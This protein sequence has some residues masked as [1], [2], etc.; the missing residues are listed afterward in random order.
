MFDKHLVVPVGKMT[1]CLTSF[2]SLADAVRSETNRPTISFVHCQPGLFT[3][4]SPAT[5]FG[6]DSTEDQRLVKITEEFWIGRTE[7]TQSQWKAVMGTEPWS[8]NRYLPSSPNHPACYVSWTDAM[9]FCRKL[10]VL[11]H[12][13]GSL[14]GDWEYTLPTEIQ[15]EYACR[16][17][18]TT[19]Y[20]FG[21]DST[22]LGRHEWVWSDENGKYG[23]PVATKSANPWGLYDMHGNLS[24]WCRDSYEQEELDPLDPVKRDVSKLRI[25]R[26]GSWGRLPKN[27]RSATRSNG[28]PSYRGDYVVGFR[29]VKVRVR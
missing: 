29:V 24:E 7:V 4:G 26:G 10:T 15:W 22:H 6:R 8:Y 14:E 9:D 19:K 12:A 5:E 1:F 3:M 18:T 21:D 27:C 20:W 2:L 25:I 28:E 17:G 16:A 11:E 23:H 13:A